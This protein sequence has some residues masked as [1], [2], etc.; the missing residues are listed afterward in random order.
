MARADCESEF[1]AAAE[2]DGIVLARAR[3]P[4]INQRGHFGLPETAE[5]AVPVLR[6][7]FEALGGDTASATAK[8]S[9]PLPGDFV[10]VDS[11]VFVEVDE[12]Q[13][14]TSARLA[15]L[16]RYP[17]E[18]RIGFDMLE[19]KRLCQELAP[20][21]DRAWRHKP[22]TGFPGE[23]GR[24]RQRA[25]NDALRDLVT[26][27]MG[28]PPLIRAAAPHRNGTTA[29]ASVRARLRAAIET[30]GHQAHD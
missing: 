28:R 2:L 7:I 19:Y 24:Q 27:L 15:T 10:H 22:A 21:S 26:P 6:S 25:Y 13:H 18:A 12:S 20:R 8:R 14:F 16:D 29:Y 3:V 4:W 9:T 5:H 23:A 30:A 17:E 11:G 1:L